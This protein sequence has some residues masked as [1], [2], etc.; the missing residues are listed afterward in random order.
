MA[1]RETEHGD[2]DAS[3][4]IAIPEVEALLLLSGCKVA[5]FGVVDLS[6]AGSRGDLQSK[7]EESHLCPDVC[8]E[9]VKSLRAHVAFQ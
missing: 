7:D 5:R 8:I 3:T 9:D 2:Q 1:P 6:Y 4:E